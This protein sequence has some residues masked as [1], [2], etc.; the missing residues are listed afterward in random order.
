MDLSSDKWSKMVS[1][2]VCSV[3]YIKLQGCFESFFF[4][5]YYVISSCNVLWSYVQQ[6]CLH[7]LPESCHL[8]W[9]ALKSTAKTVEVSTDAVNTL[10]SQQSI[11]Y[12]PLLKPEDHM[13]LQ[14]VHFQKLLMVIR[15][16]L[17]DVISY[18]KNRKECIKHLKYGRTQ[19][20]YLCVH[21]LLA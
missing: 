10:L 20:C 19:L 21:E 4:P 6:V 3:S 1:Y 13:L 16:E 9:H 15:H 14:Y 18:Q 5:G 2:D 17:L 11:T 12:M 7:Q 8:L